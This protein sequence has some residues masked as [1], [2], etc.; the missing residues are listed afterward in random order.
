MLTPLPGD[1]APAVQA[2]LP[3]VPLPASAPTA[4]APGGSSHY[5]LIRFESP[6]VTGHMSRSHVAPLPTSGV[7]V[8]LH[9]HSQ[10]QLPCQCGGKSW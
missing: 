4:N 2:C 5:R 9:S 7:T 3:A 1:P 10:A 8:V 6:W